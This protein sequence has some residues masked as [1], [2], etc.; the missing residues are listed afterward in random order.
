MHTLKLTYD[1][2]VKD[3]KDEPTWGGNIYWKGHLIKA[4]PISSASENDKVDIIDWFEKYIEDV[5]IKKHP[6][7]DN[8]YIVSDKDGERFI[9]LD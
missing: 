2:K 9:K 3:T 4:E 5:D 8:R 7:Y 1:D 6:R